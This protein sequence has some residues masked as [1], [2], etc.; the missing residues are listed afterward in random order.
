M[1]RGIFEERREFSFRD[2]EEP[3]EF[4]DEEEEEEDEEEEDLAEVIGE[5]EPELEA[6]TETTAA[7]AEP[8]EPGLLAMPANE[9]RL[10]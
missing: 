6:E 5:L 10:M 3:G 1:V 2:G 7:A 9:V 4:W 8:E